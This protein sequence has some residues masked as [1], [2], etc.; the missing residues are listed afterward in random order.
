MINFRL[1]NEKEKQLLNS[2]YLERV[3]D[4]LI[5]TLEYNDRLKVCAFIQFSF[6][7]KEPF[8]I[9]TGDLADNIILID[10]QEFASQKNKYSTQPNVK[11]IT[12][13]FREFEK[14]FDEILLKIECSQKP[15][16][17]YYREIK[18]EFN[19]GSINI[20][21]LIDELRILFIPK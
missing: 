21:S 15:D 6:T 13:K 11:V 12:K 3:Q 19:S 2:A 8:A 5:T 9:T 7:N 20:Y 1:F 4:I 17:E 16:E 18:F 10:E 14:V